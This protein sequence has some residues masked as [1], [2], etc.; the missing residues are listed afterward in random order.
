ME[1]KQP[2]T[3]QNGASEKQ[4]G[5]KAPSTGMEDWKI[6]GITIGWV[7]IALSFVLS[8]FAP[9]I[10]VY[11]GHLLVIAVLSNSGEFSASFA[12]LQLLRL[13]TIFKH[14]SNIF[15]Q[16]NCFSHKFIGKH[17]LAVWD[18]QSK[19]CSLIN[20]NFDRLKLASAS[21]VASENS[22]IG[23]C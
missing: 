21:S 16:L 14:I 17:H 5:T 20:S 18:R 19:C 15:S 10:W 4:N 22:F 9:L 7:G 8:S 13:W 2:V 3:K 12:F 6:A 1:T 11:G 23:R